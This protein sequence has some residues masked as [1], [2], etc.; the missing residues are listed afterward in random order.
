MSSTSE[1]ALASEGKKH[2]FVSSV[3]SALKNRAILPVAILAITVLACAW[4]L[5]QRPKVEPVSMEPPVTTIRTLTA[6]SESITLTVSSRG[7]VQPAVVSEVSAAVSGPVTWISPSLVAGGYLQEGAD[8]L[9]IDA[10]DYKTALAK[11]QAA[12]GQAKAEASHAGKELQRTTDLASRGL[13][14]DS[15]LQNARRAAQVAA[16]RLSN[17][18]ADLNQAQRN[19][20][21]TALS[22]PFNAIVQHRNIELGQ[23]VS[24]GQ[25]VATLY[26]AETVEVRLPLANRQLGFLSMPPSFR[27]ALPE[28][29]APDVLL[30]GNYAGE[31]YIWSGKLLRTEAGLDASNN[32]VQAI[33][34]VQQPQAPTGADHEG[35]ATIPLPIGLLVEA[36]IAGKTIDNIIA[37]PRHVIRKNTQVLI[38]APDDTLR[39]REVDILRLESDRVLIQGGLKAGEKVIV[40]PIQAVVDGMRI[41]IKDSLQSPVSSLQKEERIPT[42]DWGLATGDSSAPS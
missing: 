1:D 22:A 9:R 38:A 20:D 37:L 36:E 39:I 7:K 4:L 32:T 31:Q 33:V 19:L 41:K 30:T 35:F 27:G 8:V 26:G 40:S 18:Q 29:Q 2:R 17:A 28:E 10:S 6:E 25:S 21:R 24:S 15:E 13:A 16:G 42:G 12:K 14:S 3:K 23:N 34:R 11:S 5:L